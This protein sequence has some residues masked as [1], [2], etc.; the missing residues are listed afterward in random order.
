LAA[1]YFGFGTISCLL[2]SYFAFQVTWYSGGWSFWLTKKH[3]HPA[4]QIATAV[5]I[6]FMA[7]YSFLKNISLFYC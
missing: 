6:F 1:G 5:G 3:H 7:N 2:D 4:W